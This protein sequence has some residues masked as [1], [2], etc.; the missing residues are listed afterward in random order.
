MMSKGVKG[1]S[2]RPHLQELPAHVNRADRVFALTAFVPH[3]CEAH[4]RL[5][6]DGI[7]Q[8]CADDESAPVDD[9]KST[10]HHTAASRCLSKS[11]TSLNL[12]SNMQFRSMTSTQLA[13]LLRDKYLQHNKRWG[14]ADVRDAI[15]AH[16]P[17][18]GSLAKTVLSKLKGLNTLT[19]GVEMELIQGLALC[20]RRRGFGVALHVAD[21][22]TVKAQI[23]AIARKRYYATMRKKGVKANRFN[24]DSVA[25]SFEGVREFVL[26]KDGVPTKEKQQ[27][28]LGWT[29][30]PP[31]MMVEGVKNF[32]PVNALDCAAKRGRGSGV[33]VVRATMDANNNIH[34][35]SVSD[36]LAPEGLA[37][38]GAHIAVEK[39]MTKMETV[40]C[41]TVCIV[42]GGPALLRA[43][44][45]EYP[46]MG[47][48]RCYRH[49]I[50]QL[51]RCKT[52][53]AIIPSYEQ[54]I[55]IPKNHGNLAQKILNKVG[56]QSAL[57]AIP[58]EELCQ[59]CM[60]Q[61]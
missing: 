57:K 6:G 14:L 37:S 27:Y 9:V 8:T 61:Q 2:I 32:M 41:S 31:N 44:K 7:D 17:R 38:V 26:D 50:Q 12:K 35:I 13:A 33:L 25:K 55:R 21:A 16:D 59:V 53:R 36:V 54:M 47:I 39:I 58:K 30:V 40:A 49:L 51:Q 43:T 56:S 52:S 24:A 20:L 34:P 29:V 45:R 42:D 4:G 10:E 19:G 60:T 46:T 23:L 1:K 48:Q 3:S 28:L 11:T 5:G 18:A 22:K 15:V